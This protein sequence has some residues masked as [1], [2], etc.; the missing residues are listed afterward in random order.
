VTKKDF[1]EY[2]QKTDGCWHWLGGKDGKGYGAYWDGFKVWIA[3]RYSYT[4]AYGEI[5]KGLC[6]LHSCDNRSC[7]NPSHLWLGTRT[8]N[9]NDRDRKGRHIVTHRGPDKWPRVR[10]P[11]FS[12]FS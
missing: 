6:V 2:V 11:K 10:R 7:V 4:L 3:S 8:D 1:W 5:P 9:A 12:L